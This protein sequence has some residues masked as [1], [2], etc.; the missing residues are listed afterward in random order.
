MLF[1]EIMGVIYSILIVLYFIFRS[2][3]KFTIRRVNHEPTETELEIQSMI[4]IAEDYIDY[5]NSMSDNSTHYIMSVNLNDS[6][7][8]NEYRLE[9]SSDDEDGLDWNIVSSRLYKN[10][11]DIGDAMFRSVNGIKQKDK[12]DSHA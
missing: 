3:M 10:Q 2:K 7:L 4:D 1:F 5:L 8:I 12:G 11:S 9:V 6:V